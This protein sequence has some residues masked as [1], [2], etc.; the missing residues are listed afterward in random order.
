MRQMLSTVK[1]S[2]L[3]LVRPDAT[4]RWRLLAGFGVM[5]LV[6]LAQTLHVFIGHQ[7]SLFI[8]VLSGATI[9]GQCA[10]LTVGDLL[11]SRRKLPRWSVWLGCAL[12][13]LAFGLLIFVPH[14]DEWHDTWTA[15]ALGG[16]LVGSF[17]TGLWLLVFQ[18][19][20]FVVRARLHALEVEN[21][22]REAELSRLRVHLHPHFLLNTLNA[23]AGLTTEDPVEAC[24]LI[25]A[26]GDLVR[27]ALSEADELQPFKTE[28]AWLRRYTEILESRHRARLSF[29]W[30]VA[31]ESLAVLTPRLLLQPLVENAVKHGA[32]CQRNGGSVL[33]K[34]ELSSH[35]EVRFIVQ[36]DGPGFAPDGREGLGISLVRRRLELLCRGSSLRYEPVEVGTRVVVELRGQAEDRT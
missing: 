30:E 10:V 35:G 31:Q 9:V 26:L 33:I 5:V 11:V 19:P 20:L 3:E 21:L 6:G 32:L 13:S 14:A 4:E 36:D 27:D 7:S 17:V 24:R 16:V 8:S 15:T 12:V 22:R 23:I 18:A 29:R 1:G 28:V 25:D 34:S 2:T